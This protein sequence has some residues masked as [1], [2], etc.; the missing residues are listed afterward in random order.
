MQEAL[1]LAPTVERSQLMLSAYDSE[2]RIFTGVVCDYPVT[3]VD[4]IW[5]SVIN[6][7]ANATK[8]LS[9]YVLIPH[10][11]TSSNNDGSMKLTRVFTNNGNIF[12]LFA[13][14][15]LHSVDLASQKYNKVGA[16]FTEAKYVMTNAHIVDQGV[17]KSVVMDVQGES[18]ILHT[19]LSSFANTKTIMVQRFKTV[20]G[21]IS[22]FAAHMIQLDQPT[23]LVFFQGDL[24]FATAIDENTGEQRAMINNLEQINDPA[25]FQCN[26]PTKDCDHTMTTTKVFQ[27]TLDF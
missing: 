8:P 19:D 12:A 11:D 13:D 1:P 25:I 6:N 27:A 10:P 7:Y 26:A 22:P 24:D 3:G 2:T 18:W 16:I 4:A 17:L 5:Q 21:A 23:L 20:Q 9:S 15:T 14:G